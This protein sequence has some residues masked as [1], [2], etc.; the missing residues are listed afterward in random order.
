MKTMHA[1]RSAI[2]SKKSSPFGCL[3]LAGTLMSLPCYAQ[4]NL[5]NGMAM[6]Q[7]MAQQKTVPLEQFSGYYQMPNKVAFIHFDVREGS[8]VA[9]QL[10]DTKEYQ[11]I[12]TGET[13]FESK[14][15]GHKVEFLRDGFG[16]FAY[17][18]ILGRITTSK[19]HFDPTVVK[20]L[21]AAQLRRFEG[22]YSLKNDDGFRIDIT[23]TTNGLMVKQVWDN[24]EITFTPRSESFFL[25]EDGTFPLSFLLEGGEV[26]Q[27][28]CF[29]D[30]VWVKQK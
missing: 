6:P 22:T 24:K 27:V 5:S 29:E 1:F 13:N 21:S 8:L 28:T 16:E 9:K 18:K 19:V 2:A 15:E 30:D 20:K 23:S 17:A 25:N 7:A 12:K 14:E 10:W 4:T 26:L 3:M 11:L